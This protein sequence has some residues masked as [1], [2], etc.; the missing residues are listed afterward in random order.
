[1][2]SKKVMKEI[3]ELSILLDKIYDFNLDKNNLEKCDLIKDI[4]LNLKKNKNF[5]SISKQP[6]FINLL[7][8]VYEYYTQ[9]R[10]NFSENLY[11]NLL[12]VME[13]SVSSN[14]I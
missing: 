3:K 5:L 9:N 7:D 6:Y 4:K 11:N 8:L 14:E 13:T 10:D 2:N 1:M 12:S